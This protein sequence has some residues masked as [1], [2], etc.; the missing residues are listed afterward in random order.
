MK[1]KAIVLSGRVC[2]GKTTLAKLL[3]SRADAE[4]IKTMELIKQAL[5]GTGSSRRARH[6]AGIRLDRESHGAWL[7]NMLS[8]RL[9][10]DK[11][12]SL[13]VIDAVR[14]AEQIKCLRNSGWLVTHVHLQASEPVLARRYEHCNGAA[15]STSYG[16]VSGFS[17]ERHSNALAKIAD[18][19]I[20][21]DRCNQHDVYARVIARLENRPI[22][23][24]PVVDV[25]VG[26]QY[27]SEGKGNIAHY[28]APEYDVLV[29]VGGPNAGH[30]V[31]RID[32]KPYTFRQL[33]SGALGNKD[34]TLVIGA[35]AVISLDVLLREINELAL[36][37]EKVIIDP[38]AM[39]IDPE[40][41]AWEEAVLKGAI[42]STAQGIGRATARKILERVPDTGVRLAKNIP[43]LKHYIRDSVEFFA[44][45][46]SGG[47]RIMLE[48]TQGT[49]LSLHH[50]FYP[51]VTSR[52]TTAAACL[53]E[54]GLSP[55]H[56][57]KVMMVCRTYPIRVGD[58]V[59]GNSSGFMSQPI[60]F[61]E[62]A[63]RSGIPAS[64]F[65]QTEVGS[66]SHR[67]RRVA[68]FDWAQLR[69]SL[70]LNGPTDIALTFADYIDIKN[71]NAFRYEQLSDKTLRFIEEIEKVSGIPVS[72]ISTAFNERNIIDRRMW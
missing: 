15:E 34:A 30:K 52:A 16:E 23:A 26:G 48:G 42:G 51:H 25:L 28:L 50:G 67:P 10:N 20:D 66:V 63:E 39:I 60:D 17:T 8:A 5:P 36:T 21:S 13:V 35:G 41:I 37:F 29:R 27:G 40:D 57:R 72:M 18:V 32:D 61:S 71:R 22:I 33:P 59:T 1:P 64:E 55:R 69:R 31:F 56:V 19:V 70:L 11:D 58:S 14:S 45:C 46:L 65:A 43:S 49:S 7:A 44:T 24:L 62:I 3:V 12:L 54:A 9:V 53:A 4:L 47:K 6:N 2:S 38:Q 68:E